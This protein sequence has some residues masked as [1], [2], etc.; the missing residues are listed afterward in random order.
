MGLMLK[1]HF[2]KPGYPLMKKTV[3]VPIKFRENEEI[4]KLT[5]AGYYYVSTDARAYP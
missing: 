5:D 1:I 4:S 3:D 2:Q